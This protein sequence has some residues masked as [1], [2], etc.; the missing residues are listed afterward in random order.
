MKKKPENSLKGPQILEFPW[1]FKDLGPLQ[2]EKKN[3]FYEKKAREFTEQLQN[4]WIS[5]EIP[6]PGAPSG[7]KKKHLQPPGWIVTFR[8]G[9][10]VKVALFGG[11]EEIAQNR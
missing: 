11:S 2:A 6:A 3:I 1:K 5:L 4:P 8:C 7:L 10:L 9:G